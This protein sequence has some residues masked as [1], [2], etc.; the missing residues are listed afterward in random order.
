MLLCPVSPKSMST[1]YSSIWRH[2]QRTVRRIPMTAA[3][4]HTEYESLYVYSMDISAVLELIDGYCASGRA[5]KEEL[6][7][8]KLKDLM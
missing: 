7:A 3:S 4:P 6:L 8:W 5:P 2:P 1:R